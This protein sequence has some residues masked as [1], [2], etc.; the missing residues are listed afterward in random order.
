MGLNLFV[1][2]EVRVYIPGAVSLNSST[3]LRLLISASGPFINRI[4]EDESTFISRALPEMYF[5]YDIETCK[6]IQFNIWMM[7]D[8]VY[9]CLPLIHRVWFLVVIL[10]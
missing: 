8:L 5:A 10:T 3:D 6:Y 4:D 2:E 1:V 7:F 9:R